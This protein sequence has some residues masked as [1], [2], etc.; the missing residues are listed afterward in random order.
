[1]IGSLLRTRWRWR[2]S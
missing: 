2:A 1:M